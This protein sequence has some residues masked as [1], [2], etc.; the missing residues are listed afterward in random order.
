MVGTAVFA[1]YV[2]DAVGYTGAVGILLFKDIWAADVARLD[3]FRSFTWLMSAGGAACLIWS[4][5]VFLRT[6][7]ALG[8]S[9]DVNGP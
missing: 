4:A 8:D 7:R 2:A 3:F 5:W 9:S 1:I 6:D